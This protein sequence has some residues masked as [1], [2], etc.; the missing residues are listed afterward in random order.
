MLLG[1]AL[2]LSAA[3]AS[4]A[5]ATD[6]RAR[7]PA[8]PPDAAAVVVN[9]AAD[10]VG[11]FDK[12]FP[13]SFADD[14]EPEIDE[15]LLVI[16]LLVML[17]SSAA[18]QAWM[19]PMIVGEPPGMAYWEDALYNLIIHWAMMVVSIPL[20]YCG[21]IGIVLVAVNLLYLFP[22]SAI[23]L[24][25]R[26]LKIKRGAGGRAGRAKTQ[27][28]ALPLPKGGAPLVVAY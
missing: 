17:T 22:V 16:Y 18:G 3:V 26:H 4:S 5:A 23:N 20:V 1:P 8:P 14:L 21:G 6:A 27:R 28:S 12:Y 10:D 9:A 2:V 25:D 13:L 15:N 7:D 24:Y 11:F 19:P